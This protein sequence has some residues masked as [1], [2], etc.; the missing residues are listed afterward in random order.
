VI[1]D[2]Y[3][4]AV[5]PTDFEHV[6]VSFHGS[7]GWTD[8][9]WNAS[10]GVAEST[11]GGE[12]WTLHAPNGFGG[13]GH[14]IHFL[15]SPELGLGDKNTWLLGTQ[16]GGMWR[17]SDAG[18]TW[19]KVSET[20]IFHGGGTIYYTQAG[21]LYASGSPQSLRST[22]NGQTWI[23]VGPTEGGTTCVFGDG[24]NLWTAPALGN[25]TPYSTSP[26]DDGVAWTPYDGGAQT[27]HFGGPF[28]MAFD[29]QNRILYSSNWEQ[30]AKALKLP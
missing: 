19:T 28:E 12:S 17:T 4:L 14:A 2:T 23:S 10:A 6:L 29:P 30:G 22:D 27:W 18:E 5:D 9:K 8:S 24:E 13:Y 25:D 11:D 20:G 1:D 7:W 15:Y 26:E 3:D 21:V 16:G